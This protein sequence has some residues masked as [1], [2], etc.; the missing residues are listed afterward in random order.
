MNKPLF[1][2]KELKNCYKMAFSKKYMLNNTMTQHISFYYPDYKNA[3]EYYGYELKDIILHIAE[4]SREFNFLYWEN[5]R[6]P[7]IEIL[8]NKGWCK[9]E[10]RAKIIFE[11]L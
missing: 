8:E 1:T 5:N 10:I 4:N 11:K 2:K 3:V 6:I 7:K 9:E